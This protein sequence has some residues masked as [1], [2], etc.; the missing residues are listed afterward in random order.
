VDTEVRAKS[1]KKGE[2]KEI[3]KPQ[4]QNRPG[5][6]S[7]MTPNPVYD[8]PEVKGSN[9]LKNKAALITGGDSGIGRAVAILF[10]ARLFIRT[11]AKL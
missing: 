11:A 9:K 3:R 2:K 4:E 10:Q 5:I 7:K 1:M 6:E 8:N